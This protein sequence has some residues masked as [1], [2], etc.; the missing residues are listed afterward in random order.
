MLRPLILCGVLIVG[1]ISMAGCLS[2]FT[3]SSS[4]S[5]DKLQANLIVGKTTQAEVKQLYGQPTKVKN[6]K[7]GTTWTYIFDPSSMNSTASAVGGTAANAAIAHG[8]VAAM[9]AGH[10]AG[11][12][13]GILGASIA[14]SQAS[15]AVGSAMKAD[16]SAKTLTIDFDKAGVVKHY[17]LN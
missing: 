2:N 6:S 13:A 11:G 17:T 1:M 16:T 10:K 7:S 5:D 15:S 14:S 9:S 12:A 8:T 4:L 3:S